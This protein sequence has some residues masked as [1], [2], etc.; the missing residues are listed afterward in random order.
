MD[1][2]RSPWQEIATTAWPSLKKDLQSDVAIVGGGISGIATLFYLL[3]LTDKQIVLVERGKIG[4]GATGNNAG[5][6]WAHIERP[7][8]ELVE[9][10]GFEPVKEAFLELDHGWDE[11]I[12][13]HKL[14]GLENNVEPLDNSGLGFGFT[15]TATLE[16]SLQDG[17]LFRKMGRKKWE[18]FISE[19]IEMEGEGIH[20]VPREVILEKLQTKDPSYIG[21]L[22][23]SVDRA[24]TNSYLFC[25]RLLQY[26]K[27]RFPDRFEVYEQTEITQIEKNTLKFSS[28]TITA[29]V[30]VICTNGYSKKAAPRA[31]YAAA[32]S[33][34]L[35]NDYSAA[36]ITHQDPSVPYWHVTNCDSLTIFAGPEYANPALDLDEWNKT[37]ALITQFT[38]RTYHFNPTFQYQWYGIMGYTPTGLRWVGQDRQNPHIWYN[39]GCNGIGIVHAVASGE[40][41][42][43]LLNGETLKPSLFSQFQS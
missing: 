33:T 18:F 16:R 22:Y 6:A 8:S 1:T 27:N 28:G 24:R 41:I 3:T 32:C 29:D 23:D 19:E 42:A 20:R 36:F 5:F 17:A 43:R 38:Q 12:R 4:C 39:L 11:Y 14:I 2:P 10:F 25:H 21:L 40:R 26:L 13:I 15:D 34:S 30:L 35:P 31:A 9:E 37:F 7:V